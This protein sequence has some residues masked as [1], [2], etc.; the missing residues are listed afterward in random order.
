M[1]HQKQGEPTGK[2]RGTVKFPFF[3][4]AV[5]ELTSAGISKNDARSI[6]ANAVRRLQQ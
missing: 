6:A 5:I 1:M 3:V 2:S 4:N